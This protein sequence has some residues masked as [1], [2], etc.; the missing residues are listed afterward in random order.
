MFLFK[1]D[2]VYCITLDPDPDRAWNSLICSLKSNERQWAISSDRSGQ[3]SDCERIAQ[4][5]HVK[6][7]TVSESLV[8]CEKMSEWA[9]R[10]EFL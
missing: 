4:A 3:M 8:F 1:I 6:R 2:S 10:S 5:A 7:A 9:I